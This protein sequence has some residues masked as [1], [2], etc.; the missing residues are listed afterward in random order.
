MLIFL[1]STDKYVYLFIFQNGVCGWTVCKPNNEISVFTV[2]TPLP[3]HYFWPPPKKYYNHL[4]K[5]RDWL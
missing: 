4:H 1:Y 5:I 3:S 2:P